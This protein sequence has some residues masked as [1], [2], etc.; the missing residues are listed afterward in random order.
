MAS[1]LPDDLDQRI[2]AWLA[3]KEP[4]LERLARAIW[5]D[6]GLTI[7]G[8]GAA[9]M[10]AVGKV[11]DD[12]AAAWADKYADFVNNRLAR[13]WV[14][15]MS[16]G[17]SELPA[18]YWQ[19][20]STENI[21]KWIGKRGPTLLKGLTGSQSKAVGQI[22]K[23]FASE[24]PVSAHTLA[25]ILQP[26]VGLTPRQSR[27]LARH[28]LA[29]KEAG[30]S[31]ESIRLSMAAMGNKLQTQRAKVVARTELAAAYNGGID[32]AIRGALDDEAFESDI[33]KT[34]RTQADERVCAI[35]GPL[36]NKSIGMDEH[37]KSGSFS[38]PIPPAHPQCRC[39]VLYEEIDA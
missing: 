27:I 21:Q 9:Q 15:A 24:A 32:T 14:E 5:K 39:V 2:N 35:C 29:L 25:V 4:E 17:A 37:F 31:T 23:F 16:A 12:L 10:V 1:I 7:T 22:I 13:R 19:F 30:A 8:G 11:P 34:W 36:D 28:Y 20:L 3:H 26:A 33:A 18:R 38:G 6:M